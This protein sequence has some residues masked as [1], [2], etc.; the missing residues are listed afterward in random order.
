M[1]L[2]RLSLL[3]FLFSCGPKPAAVG[4]AGG[5]VTDDGATVDIPAGALASSTTI[6][7]AKLDKAPL[8]P[9]TVV[10][11]S[12]AYSFT[13]SADFDEDVTITLPF[14][15]ARVPASATAT[16]GLVM[17]SQEKDQSTWTALP[18]GSVKGST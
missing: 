18:V 7:I 9:T 1:T 3:F 11:V 17:L 4:T 16:S 13:A 6:T 5:Q 8:V 15:P 2:T 12:D 10:A 14:D